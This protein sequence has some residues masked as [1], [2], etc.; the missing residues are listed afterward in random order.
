MPKGPRKFRFSFEKTG[1][2]RFGGLS[3]FQSFCKSLGLRHFLQLGCAGR[4]SARLALCYIVRVNYDK[5]LEFLRALEEEQVEYVL[6]GGVALNLTGI[7]RATQV[8]DIVLRL[9]KQ[10]VERLKNALRRTWSDPAIEEIRYD[11]LEGD[12]PAITCG[13]PDEAF[14]NR[15]CYSIWRDVPL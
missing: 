7:T 13:P 2:T 10:N 8:V 15:Y 4:H 5:V 14:G 3:L 11:E 12:Y 6:V 1:L 9:E